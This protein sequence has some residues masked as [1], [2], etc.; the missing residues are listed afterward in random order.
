MV[1]SDGQ[2]LTHSFSQS[3]FVQFPEN[4]L[5]GLTEE[6]FIRIGQLLRERSWRT[7]G[8]NGVAKAVGESDVP[9]LVQC[10]IDDFVEFVVLHS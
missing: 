4:E 1:F 10:M 3:V 2:K 5:D 9:W 7:G 8:S 6:Q